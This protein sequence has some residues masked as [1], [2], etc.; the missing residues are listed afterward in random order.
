MSKHAGKA[1]IL[2]SQEEPRVYL[3]GGRH[4]EPETTTVLSSQYLVIIVPPFTEE[5]N[6]S[7]NFIDLPKTMI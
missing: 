4:S 7:V 5:G 1:C 3:D 6:S 2:T